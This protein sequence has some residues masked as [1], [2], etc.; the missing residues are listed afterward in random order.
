MK[1]GQESYEKILD[2]LRNNEPELEGKKQLSSRILKQITEPLQ[3]KGLSERISETL[4]GWAEVIWMRWTVSILALALIGIF[5]FQ[6]VNLNQ[7]ISGIEKQ[8]VTME[9]S[10]VSRQ[11]DLNRGQILLMK[12]ISEDMDDSITVSRADLHRLL[13]SYES[14]QKKYEILRSGSEFDPED[15]N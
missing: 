10:V 5:L 1:A 8:L 12:L 11:T 6:Q 7:K 9:A 13:D 3:D 14:L 4:F 2:A 15:K